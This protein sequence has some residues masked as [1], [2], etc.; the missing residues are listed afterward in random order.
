MLQRTLE[1]EVMDTPE[2]ARDY[3][4]MDHGDVNRRFVEDLLASAG[5]EL[6]DVLDLGTGTAQIPIELCEREIDCRIMAVD[7]AI[8]MLDVARVNIEIAG[9]T[10]QIQLDRVDA[11]D[12]LYEDD[13]F[14]TVISN[15]IIHHI[16]EPVGVLREA[17]RVLRPGGWLFF[18]D[19]SRPESEEQLQRLVAA[20]A[21]QESD[22]AR[23][24]FADSLR[25]ALSV[26][27]VRVLASQLSLSP[28]SC[29]THQRP[30]LDTIAS[31]G[32]GSTAMETP[33][34]ALFLRPSNPLLPS[35]AFTLPRGSSASR[36]C[37]GSPRLAVC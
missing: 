26:E 28:E 30:P 36:P 2:E 11:K 16:P 4:A 14:D 13:T 25:A 22:H 18:R 10:R 17:L 19:L 35:N 27:E 12:L 3:D 20:Y 31:R 34:S 6:G 33:P 23:Q 21:G 29:S 5:D 8:A 24:M 9:A 7:A 37:C 32:V 1:P 15:S